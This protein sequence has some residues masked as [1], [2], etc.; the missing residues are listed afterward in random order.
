M[1]F[2]VFVHSQVYER[3]LKTAPTVDK[4]NQENEPDEISRDGEEGHTDRHSLHLSW[5]DADYYSPLPFFSLSPMSL[6][7]YP[8]HKTTLL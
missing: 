6:N 7:H 4:K 3:V 1:E 5:L 2:R 8:V